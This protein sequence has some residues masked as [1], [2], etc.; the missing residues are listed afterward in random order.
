MFDLAT[1]FISSM[2]LQGVLLSILVFV[3]TFGM[4][5]AI[6]SLVLVKLPATYFKRSHDRTF[7]AKHPPIIRWLAVLGKNLL[8][9]VLVVIGILLS[10]PGVPG[11]GMLTI[12]LGIMLLDFPGKP[13]FEYWLVSRPKIL[14]GINKLRERFSKP[15]LVLD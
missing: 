9:A 7:L 13:R 3:I 11:Q 8:G 12:L 1:D 4:S 10:L 14:Q 6:V 15:A 5:L 2:T